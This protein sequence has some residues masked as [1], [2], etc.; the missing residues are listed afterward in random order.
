[1]R[2]ASCVKRLLKYAAYVDFRSLIRMDFYATC[3][4]MFL[5][6]ISV[7]SSVEVLESYL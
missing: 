5:M 2:G 4:D 7:S 6:L 3:M 1:M